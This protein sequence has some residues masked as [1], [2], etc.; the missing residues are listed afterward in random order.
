[1]KIRTVTAPHVSAR[2]SLPLALAAGMLTLAG[3]SKQP[4]SKEQATATGEPAAAETSTVTEAPLPSE[5]PESLRGRWGLVNGDCTS[6]RG[7]AKGLLTIDATRLTF[8]ESVASLG[9]VKSAADDAIE[10]EFAFSGEGQSW[11]LDVS[12][13]SPDGGHTLVRKDTG[14]DAAPETLTY[15]RCP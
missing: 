5:I 7:D 8:Y 11:K 12:L 15:T 2:W 10:A 13:A 9:T 14:P 4:A 3:C 6:T 1:M